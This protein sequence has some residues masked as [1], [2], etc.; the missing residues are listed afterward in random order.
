MTIAWHPRYN[1]I[2][3]APD[4]RSDGSTVDSFGRV[5]RNASTGQFVRLI[6]F[7]AI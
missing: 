4:D 5:Q 6:S 2:A 3:I 1:I 7:G